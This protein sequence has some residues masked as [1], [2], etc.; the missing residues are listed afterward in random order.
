MYIVENRVIW[1]ETAQKTKPDTNPEPIPRPNCMR[2]I[3]VIFWR[4]IRYPRRVTRYASSA[5]RSP[6]ICGCEILSPFA[7]DVTRRRPIEL[8]LS[9]SLSLV[10]LVVFFP[11]WLNNEVDAPE[12]RSRSRS[13]RSGAGAEASRLER[14]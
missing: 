8:R 3:F 9:L 11:K 7:E 1:W 10:P 2:R 4:R 5:Y 6:D 12:I 14:N 13:R